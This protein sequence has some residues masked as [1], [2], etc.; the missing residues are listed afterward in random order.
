[1]TKPV[2]GKNMMRVPGGT[3]TMGDDN[4]YP[5]ERPAH[6][7]TVAP[8]LMDEHPVT[9]AEFGR[10]VRATGYRTTAEQSPGPG[11]FPGADPLDLVPGSLVFV[12]SAG[13][14]PLDDW[15]RWW[16]WR[17]GAYW[18][19]PRGPGTTTGG[20]ERHP[21]VHISFQDALAYAEWAGKDLPTEAEWEFAA[22]GGK[23]AS[24]YAWGEEFT[25]RGRIMANTWH[26]RFPWENL[27]SHGF[28]RTSPVGRFPPNEFG[29]VDMIGNVWEW[30]KSV[31]TEDHAHRPA[32][33]AETCC[34]PSRYAEVLPEDERRVMKGG[35]HLCAP[36]YCRRYRPAARQ[37][38]AVRS[39]ASHL[40]FRCIV[41]G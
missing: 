11:D 9:N 39:S 15:R 30:T 25:P 28:D 37:G 27:R 33:N 12:P 3:F 17:P 1:M 6:A 19:A 10:F 18:R 8:F 40:G 36:S 29:L 32:G 5:E 31:W 26:G 7:M 4:H 34:T 21:V 2:A 23:S 14:V 38:Q 41:R 16:Q 24:T 13:P 20:Y 22:R 35:S